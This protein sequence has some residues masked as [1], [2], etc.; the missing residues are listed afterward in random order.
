[1]PRDPAKTRASLLDCAAQQ[2]REAGYYGTDTNRI[3]RQAGFAPQTFYRHFED[4]R[5][6]FVEVYRRWSDALLASIEAADG[7]QAVVQAVVEH[8]RAW[9]T[10][11]A[12][13]LA[14]CAT[15]EVVRSH[16]LG[17]RKRQLGVLRRLTG[18]A[19]AR[20]LQLMWSIE[21]VADG[22]ALG[23]AQALRVSE[24]KLVALLAED[25]VRLGASSGAIER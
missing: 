15:D 22:I 6:A 12:S 11:R 7:A 25:L 23:E 9:G 19:Q 8:H 18:L 3:A 1:M 13:L 17:E 4:K 16:R 21:R 5:A 24:R 10:F 2:F 14:L 20:V